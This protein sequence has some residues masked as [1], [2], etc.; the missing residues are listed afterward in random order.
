VSRL[1]G[2]IGRILGRRRDLVGALPRPEERSLWITTELDD[3]RLDLLAL[4]DVLAC[5]TRSSNNPASS[6]SRRDSLMLNCTAAHGLPRPNRNE[7][8]D[9]RVNRRDLHTIA[10]TR[11]PKLVQPCQD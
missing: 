1:V 11:D 3:E 2:F 5:A 8:R 7:S 10:L 4:F 6:R 9:Q